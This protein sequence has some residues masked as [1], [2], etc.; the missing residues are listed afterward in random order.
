MHPSQEEV[1]AEYESVW[2]ALDGRPIENLVNLPLMSDPELEAAMR[3]FSAVLTPAYFSD[4]LLY[5]L[6]VCRVV[7]IT[8]QRGTSRDSVSAYT[9]FGVI[10]GWL[11]HRYG[12]GYRFSKLACDV[13]EKHGFSAC[14]PLVYAGLGATAVWTEPIAAAVACERRAYR[15]AIETGDPIWTCFSM[16]HIVAHAFARNDPLDKVWR[17][18]EVGLLVAQKARYEDAVAVFT[19]EQRF[20]AT[21]QGGTASIS[22]FSD[23]VFDETAFEAQLTASRMP[24]TICWYWILKLKARFLSGD[25]AEALAA[26]GTAQRLLWAS[27]GQIAILDYFFYTALTVSALHETGSPR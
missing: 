12:D 25:Y 10:L 21:M 24:L 6:Q 20:I 9:A 17:E 13:V 11:F 23:V 5:R 19:S 7:T 15:A 18:T 26:S 16:F 4:Q 22:T 3:V 8:V 27:I 1:Q 2:Q 14:R